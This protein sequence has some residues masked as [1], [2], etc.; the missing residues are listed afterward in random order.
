MYNLTVI[1]LGKNRGPKEFC[2]K[3]KFRKI[4]RETHERGLSRQV[5]FIKRTPPSAYICEF[6][7]VF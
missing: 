3:R 7:E 1:S 5:T 6:C 2:K 4:C